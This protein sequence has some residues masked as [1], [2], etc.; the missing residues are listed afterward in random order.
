ME[1]SAAAVAKRWRCCGAVE[2][3]YRESSCWQ[4]S[5]SFFNWVSGS[6]SGFL[7]FIVA[8]FVFVRVEGGGCGGF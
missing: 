6:G 7:C 1:R 8:G 5:V 4:I 2:A 3:E